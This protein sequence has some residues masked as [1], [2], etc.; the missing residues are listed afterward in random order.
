MRFVQLAA[1][2]NCKRQICTLHIYIT[3]KAFFLQLLS[4][5]L[6]WKMRSSRTIYPIV[7]SV[8]SNNWPIPYTT[9]PSVIIT[10]EQLV[11]L[12]FVYDYS[13]SSNVEYCWIFYVVFCPVCRWMSALWSAYV[14]HFRANQIH[15]DV[16]VLGM[17][18]MRL[19]CIEWWTVI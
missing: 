3:G 12:C 2:F 13:I 9:L 6:L 14:I 10:D 19:H 15:L 17:S 8:N 7:S 4:D 16:A 5:M 1:M 18:S 11:V